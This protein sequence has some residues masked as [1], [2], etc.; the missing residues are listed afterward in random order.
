MAQ[1]GINRRV[2]SYAQMAVTFQTWLKKNGDV[3]VRQ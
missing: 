2:V 3:A 1:E